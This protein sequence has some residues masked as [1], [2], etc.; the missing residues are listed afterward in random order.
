MKKAFP[1]IIICLI[2][3]FSISISIDD[4]KKIA[5]AGN[6]I[7]S[8]TPVGGYISEN[9]TWTLEESP[10]I[11][12]DN[13]VVAPNIT[14]TIEPGVA[15]N[16]DFWALNVQGTLYARGNQTHRILFQSN[17]T[18]IGPINSA[19]IYFEQD[20]TPWNETTNEG[21]TIEFAEIDLIYTGYL[22]TIFISESASPKMSNCIIHTKQNT[23]IWM[24]NGTFLN[25]TIFG[26]GGTGVIVGSGVIS[27]NIIKGLQYGILFGAPGSEVYIVGNLLINN[28]IAIAAQGHE[29]YIANNT[30]IQNER[31]I[32]VATGIPDFDIIC[33]NIHSNDYNIYVRSEDPRIIIN[34]TYNWWGTTNTSLID[35]K[36]LDQKD[37]RR[38]SLVNYAPF[39]T[40]PA[41]FPLDELPPTTINDYDGLWHNTDFTITLMATD[42]VIGVA[43]TYYRINNGPVRTV[44][45]DGQPLMTTE[46]AN[47]TLEYWSVDNAENEEIPHKFLTG[48]KLDKTAPVVA[49]LR[50]Q[51][52]GDVEPNQPV[53][54]LVNATDSLSGVKDVILSYSI[55]DSSAWTDVPMTFNATTGFYEG[56]IQGQQAGTAVKYK[57]TVYDS[58]GNYLVE[59]NDGQYYVY[60]IIPEFQSVFILLLFLL[61]ATLAVV[62]SK[63][64]IQI[65]TAGQLQIKTEFAKI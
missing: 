54:V 34:V 45:V 39:L 50:R 2:L 52:E 30:I 7:S 21:C 51:P 65:K 26:E 12:I 41:K 42:D 27:Y 56:I 46:G 23:A 31:G 60:T 16:F 25:N 3:I 8:G 6:H 63:K 48:I 44:S 43:E 64:C 11:F 35:Q 32:D 15:I 49:E 62:F 19:R 20:S 17:E 61:L 22:A 24:Y 33:N 47:N 5:E 36:I 58:A 59:D 14:L 4:F 28:W 53:K 29:S 55:D 10:Y 37:D 38:L 18:Q 9:T 13:V 1:S 57:I 40:S